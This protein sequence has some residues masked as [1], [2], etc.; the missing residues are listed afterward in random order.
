ML[1][2]KVRSTIAKNQ[3]I[4]RRDITLVAVSGGVDSVVLLEILFRLRKE[5]GTRLI[6]AHLDHGLRGTESAQDARFVE[7]IGRKKRIEVRSERLNVD[8]ISTREKI[9]IEQ[10]AR[11]VRLRYLKQTAK[12]VGANKIAL[13][14]TLDDRVETL[15]HHLIRGTGPTGLQGIRPVRGQ[16]IR[17]LIDASRQEILDFAE[18]KELAWREDR[19]NQELIYTRNRIRH[20]IIPALKRLNPRLLNSLGR[21]AELIQQEQSALDYLLDSPWKEVFQEGGKGD[22]LLSLSRLRKFPD[23]VQ[24]LLMRR[25]ISHARGDLNDIERCHIV[26]LLRLIDADMAHGE[27][28]LPGI[29]A[30]R[31]GD[32][33][34][35]TITDEKE[36]PQY[37]YPL[38]LGRTEFPELGIVVELSLRKWGQEDTFTKGQEVELAD[39][40]RL[41]FPLRLRNRHPGDRFRPL[42]LSGT[43]KLKD[44][45]ID[46]GI[47]FY[48][49]ALLPLICDREKIVWVVGVRLA[50]S[51]RVTEDTD[52]VVEM[53]AERL[54]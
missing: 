23:Q 5:L 25:A 7:E 48:E 54:K 39:A 12:E 14:H 11:R 44:F 9:G 15:I 3:M 2:D 45:L 17:P 29:I 33:L 26:S 27:L 35:L 51:V 22:V 19:T 42:G 46:E 34:R 37:E 16:Y 1:L 50:D 28:H 30:R 41:L 40:D 43:K 4:V 6:I 53:R 32:E 13:G 24:G 38:E 31:Q 47:P 52:R 20:E 8:A 36:T 49:R 10:A 18:E 21:T